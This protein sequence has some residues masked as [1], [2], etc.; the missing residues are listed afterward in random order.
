MLEK[1]ANYTVLYAED[2]DGVRKNVAE[3][4][5]L[6]FKKVILAKDGQEAYEL[7]CTNEIDLLITDIKMPRLSGLELAKKIRK[8]NKKIEI[9]ILSAHTEVDFMLEAVELNLIRYLIK[10][11]TE[12]K[13]IDVLQKFLDSQAN[14]NCHKLADGWMYDSLEKI[15]IH[16]DN[17]YELTKKEAKFL[18]VLLK[19][20]SVLSYE[21]IESVLWGDEYMSLNAMRLMIK[22]FRKKLPEGLIKNIQGFGYKL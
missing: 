3:M 22:N 13:L 7:F 2:N 18:D 21:E 11:I 10:P 9:V 14:E 4:L 15:I 12:A 5:E 20:K 16:D 17:M 19:R 8:E 6:L 1:L